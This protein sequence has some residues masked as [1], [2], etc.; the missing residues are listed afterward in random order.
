MLRQHGVV[1]KFVE[2][3]GDGLS[4]LTL[5]DRATIANMCPEY[6]ATVSFFPV[7]EETLRY[8]I[9]TGRDEALVELVARYTQA[10]GLFRT[11][12]TPDPVFT[13]TLGLDMSTVV[14]SLAGPKRPQDR[15]RLDDLKT[16]FR[17]ALT[18]PPGPKGLGIEPAH[19]SDSVA[20]DSDGARFDLKHGDVTIAAITSC[21]NTSNPTVMVGAGLLAK[22]GGGTGARRQA[23]G[24]DQH[25][26]RL[27]GRR[28]L[29]TGLCLAA[30]P[31][32]TAFPHRWLWL[33][34]LYWQFWPFS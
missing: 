9:G 14:P 31:G 29:P 28:A 10:Q 32:S 25:G 6:G 27:Q 7:D 24:E 2:F 20:V 13:E 5:P 1:G 23:L 15:V 12:D 18:T 34:H 4:R 33:H 17:K 19:T 11:D 16:S 21:T 3:Y 30:L 26:P 8:L 22:K